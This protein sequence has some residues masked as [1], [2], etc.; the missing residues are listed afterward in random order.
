MLP[1]F[2]EISGNLPPGLHNVTW[3]EV[4]HR[5]GYNT[6]RRR[7][8]VGLKKGLD[9]LRA[10]GCSQYYLNGS[11]ITAKLMPSDFDGCYPLQGINEDLLD[12]VL[13]NTEN[14][15][16]VQRLHYRGEFWPDTNGSMVEFYL[17]DNRTYPVQAKGIVVINLKGG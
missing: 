3:E 15:C 7:L 6:T 2:E 5:Y 10:A 8:L 16:E 17:R 13:L 1:E 4:V 11:F 12:P 9:A 14:D